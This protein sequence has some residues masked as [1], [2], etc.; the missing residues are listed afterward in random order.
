MAILRLIFRLIKGLYDIL[1]TYLLIW[2]LFFAL[3]AWG[4]H[5]LLTL[6]VGLGGH[7][8]AEAFWR[9]TERVKGVNSLA[10]RLVA[11]GLLH[12]LIFW[13]LRRPLKRAQDWVERRVDALQRRLARWAQRHPR[14]RLV[15]GFIFSTVVTLLLVP[16]VIQP[17]LVPAR[18]DAHTWARRAANLAD[19]TATAAL[20]ESVIGLYRK[21]LVKP[22]MAEGVSA[23][24]FNSSLASEEPQYEATFDGSPV[25]RRPV[26]KNPLMDRWDPLIRQV[27]SGDRRAFSMVK[28]FIRVES[29]GHQFAVSRTGCLGLT[30]FCAPT[31][32]S[33]SFRKIFGIGQIYPCRC[34]GACTV[35]RERRQDLESGDLKRVEACRGSYPCELSDA[36]LDPRKSITAGWAY[37][38]RLRDATG[39]NIY[40]MY[41][42]YNSGPGVAKKLWRAIGDPRAGLKVI[43]PLL[44]N[45]LRPHFGSRSDARAKSLLSISLPKLG[46]FYQGYYM[47]AAGPGQ[48]PDERTAA[49]VR[50]P[51]KVLYKTTR[52]EPA[53]K[54]RARP[55]RPRRRSP[56]G[57][58]T[59]SRKPFSQPVK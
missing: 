42:G 46:R 13:L 28:A 20:V 24:D 21:M 47:A 18:W 37:I 33:K 3:L 53:R 1:A 22:V 38:R 16:F 56:P 27:V 44:A 10:L 31:A 5:E 52:G 12:A 50:E 29:G 25:L 23:E 58:N 34:S 45:A 6:G 51:K 41:I 2:I 35:P 30:Q 19:G 7:E 17:T 57:K 54:K 48:R 9:W 26:G 39:G 4:F 14:G 32:R 36:R 8:S 15:F 11:F 49:E 43:G 40:L 59:R 55:K